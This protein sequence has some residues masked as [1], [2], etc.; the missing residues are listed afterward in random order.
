MVRPKKI[1]KIQIQPNST[2]FKPHG[3]PLSKLEEIS[4]CHD[5]LEAIHLKYIEKLDQHNCAKKMKISQSTFQ[6]ILSLA[7]Q[8]I[9]KA[10]INGKAIR[11]KSN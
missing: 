9:A 2:Y 1:R 8:N 5:E 6:R 10:L 11:I 3:I 7:N 4:I